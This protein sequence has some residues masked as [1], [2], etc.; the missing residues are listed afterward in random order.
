MQLYK[1]QMKLVIRVYNQ[2]KVSVVTIICSPN[3]LNYS[4]FF[5]MM[6]VYVQFAD[7]V[8]CF[9]QSIQLVWWW[10]RLLEDSAKLTCPWPDSSLRMLLL[11][12]HSAWPWFL[13][14]KQIQLDVKFG[15][16]VTCNLS[17]QVELTK[18]YHRDYICEVVKC[19][20]LEQLRML[21]NWML[22]NKRHSSLES[23]IIITGIVLSR[24]DFIFCCNNYCS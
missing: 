16:T 7:I 19:Y 9:A 12:F 4:L 8:G 13:V 18:C 21:A 2:L 10:W 23:S 3:W 14:L 6:F 24:P 20:H 11:L 1:V 5:N 22:L 17:Q 15:Q